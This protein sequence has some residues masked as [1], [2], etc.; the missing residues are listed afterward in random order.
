MHKF[1]PLANG[2]ETGD[3][4]P[5]VLNEVVQFYCNFYARNQQNIKKKKKVINIIRLLYCK[6]KKI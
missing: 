6:R 4:K 3:R 5:D 1:E 2:K